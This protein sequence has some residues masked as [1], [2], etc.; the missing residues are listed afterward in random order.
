MLMPQPRPGALGPLFIALVALILGATIASQSADGA[1]SSVATLGAHDAHILATRIQSDARRADG[2]PSAEVHEETG[3]CG[4]RV[5]TVLYRARPTSSGKYGAYVVQLVTG[6]GGAFTSARLME[7]RTP[8]GY[9]YGET[10]TRLIYQFQLARQAG[11]SWGVST[12]P[13]GDE[14]PITTPPPPPGHTTFTAAE[15]EQEFSEALTVLKKAENRSPVGPISRAATVASV[16]LNV[17]LAHPERPATIPNYELNDP[18]THDPAKFLSVQSHVDGVSWSSWGGSTATGSGKVV[19]SSS[20]T[21]PGHA[22]PYVSQSVA[23]SIVASDLVSC[24]GQ[25]LYTAYTLTLSGAEAEPRDFAL[26]R[27]RSLPCRMQALTYY[28]GIEKVANTT[29]DCLFHGVTEQLPSGFGYLDYCRMQWKGWGNSSTVGTGIARAVTLP[30]SCD[31]HEECDYGVRVHLDQPEWCP[32]YG[33][34][35]TRERLEVF[36]AGV[37]LSSEP[38]TRTGAVSPSVERRL[39]ATI[40]HGRA[41]VFYEGVRGSQ[42]CDEVPG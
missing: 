31:G 42:G 35:Y 40:G 32:A 1:S 25:Q 22:Q 3:C 4:V 41:R 8:R 27:T 20:D 19:V 11:H 30:T 7:L 18:D 17:P 34:S 23:V 24:G 39:R 14:I 2:S 13:K 12:Y 10:Q 21:R 29:G 9:R 37:P 6:R 28:A 5:L 36:G 26:V 38:Q 16:Y 33:M 15:L